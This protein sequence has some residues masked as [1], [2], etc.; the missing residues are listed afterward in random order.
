[1]AR[2]ET[3][4]FDSLEDVFLDLAD[5]P[6]EIKI[7]ALHAMAAPAEAAVRQT[8]EAM[9]VRDPESSVHILDKVTHTKPKIDETG[10]FTR[11]TFSGKRRRGNTSTRNTEIAFM[12]EYGKEGQQARPFIRQ[13]AET[14]VNQITAP[15]EQII[16]NWFET[17]AAE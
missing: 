17:T 9:G 2:L 4:G 8:G 16:G 3:T 10:G 11:V 12:N 14:A 5:I 7:A 13:A 6:A 15:G 1:M